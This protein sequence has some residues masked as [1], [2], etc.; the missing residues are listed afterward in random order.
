MPGAR[1]GAHVTRVRHRVVSRLP[2]A[3]V[4]RLRAVDLASL[5]DRAIL[6]LPALLTVILS[7]S[8][9]G[10]L[11]P[12]W[13][14][15][16]RMPGVTALAV[17]ALTLL[18]ALQ[19]ARGQRPWVGANRPYAVGTVALGLLGVWVL[20]ST[21]WSHAPARSILDYDRV[22]LYALV[23]VLVG[24]RGRR[25]GDVRMFVRSIAG[26][27]FAVCLCGLITRLFPDLWHLAAATGD[28]RLSYPLPYWN[29]LGLL[30]GIGFVLCFAL[31]C[32]DRETA[33]GRVL[34]AAA[35][36]V[37]GTTLLLTFSRGAIASTAIGMVAML[38]LGRPRALLSGMVVGVPMVGV[39]V[40][41]GYQ[42]GLLASTEPTSA[43]A[44][45]QGHLVAVVVIVCVGISALG[46][47]M[48]LARDMRSFWS[49]YTQ[50][51]PRR[52]WTPPAAVVFTLVVAM[53]LGAPAAIR[54]EY[55]GFV[56][57]AGRSGPDLRGRLDSAGDNGRADLWGVALDAFRDEP[58][59]GYGAGTYGLQ[60]DHRG[61]GALKA[62]DAHGLYVESLAE[63]GLVGFGLVCF[64]VLLV[65][66]GAARA[67]R[68]TDRALGGTLFGV[69]VVWAVEAGVDWMWE[70]PAVSVWFFG[71]GGLLLASSD[72]G[73]ARRA[74]GRRGHAVGAVAVIGCIA[75]LVLPLRV[76]LS[77][78]ALRSAARAFARGDC[79]DAMR[80]ARTSIKVLSV[81]PEPH[82]L[83]GYCAA[84]TGRPTVAIDAMRDAVR[85]DPDNWE[86]HYG[87]AIARAASGQDPRPLLRLAVRMRP[88]DPRQTPSEDLVALHALLDM[89]ID[90]PRL[91]RQ[92][93][94]VATVPQ[95]AP[96]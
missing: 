76:H 29:A 91:W 85:L 53:L 89:Q 1:L 13:A 16:R 56:T 37:L 95:G 43:A 42:A 62:D 71:A 14:A 28:A 32:D 69:G 10:F 52:R 51:L 38:L 35:L 18:L 86:T 92:R 39:A 4:S 19:L 59:R 72:R 68:G 63:L 46:R 60:L 93:A 41:A 54:H 82:L 11:P 26:A 57:D 5:G 31:T 47:H 20:L 55:R 96:P 21:L 44:T 61:M 2:A 50:R 30:A 84:R 83:L 9:G 70:I 67:A 74:A 23:F 78:T 90:D 79:D 36:P 24:M 87:L 34:G 66:G 88:R 40:A 25:P 81:R 8:S 7:F 94:R 48:L 77:D 15:S 22:L 6:L 17:V 45:S 80:R 73:A 33:I 12:D 49:G 3:A 58:L 27:A 65:L 64:V 75:L